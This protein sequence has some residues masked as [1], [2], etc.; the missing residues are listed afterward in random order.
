MLYKHHQAH[1]TIIPAMEPTQRP[2]AAKSTTWRCQRLVDRDS[3]PVCT[4]HTPRGDEGAE[5]KQGNLAGTLR[6][7][8]GIKWK[9]EE[10]PLCWTAPFAQRVFLAV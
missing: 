5:L 7:D 4:Q 6:F 8:L 9:N 3:H 2:P 10:F 1:N